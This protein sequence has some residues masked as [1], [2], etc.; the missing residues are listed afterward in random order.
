[1]KFFGAGQQDPCGH[2]YRDE[3]TSHRDGFF[4][5]A[6][7]AWQGPNVVLAWRPDALYFPTARLSAYTGLRG[8]ASGS[9]HQFVD[10]PAFDLLRTCVCCSKRSA[11]P[12]SPLVVSSFN[13]YP[14]TPLG[15]IARLILPSFA[16]L[17][18]ISA[19]IFGW[20]AQYPSVDRPS[21]ISATVTNPDESCTVNRIA[22]LNVGDRSRW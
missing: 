7:N 1:M 8:N 19:T 3:K 5:A 9:R 18:D 11:A 10:Y 2:T 14:T 17:L 21:F 16:R 4:R 13:P 22:S 6:S 15:P 20:A 12:R